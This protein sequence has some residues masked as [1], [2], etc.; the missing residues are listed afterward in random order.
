MVPNCARCKDQVL[1]YLRLSRYLC[2][3]CCAW[4][5]D[6]IEEANQRIAMKLE[7][8]EIDIREAYE[9]M[10]DVCCGDADIWGAIPYAGSI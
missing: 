9:S 3:A 2:A 8:N 4:A 6:E 5:L 1:V 7:D 10:N